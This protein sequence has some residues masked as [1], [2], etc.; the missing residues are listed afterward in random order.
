MSVSSH[1]A[2]N[3]EHP[4]SFHFQQKFPFFLIPSWDQV[5][6][7]QSSRNHSLS[8]FVLLDCLSFLPTWF[9][10]TAFKYP[11]VSPISKKKKSSPKPHTPFK[12]LHKLS[13]SHS[14]T[15]Q[16]SHLQRCPVILRRKLLD[17]GREQNI[18]SQISIY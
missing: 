9:S 3:H 16:K 10:Q 6:R 4:S 7:S 15:F 17:G 12:Q 11:Q 1:Q 18:Q 14:Q 2:C 5:P 13:P 8:Y